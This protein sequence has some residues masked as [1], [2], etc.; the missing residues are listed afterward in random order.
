ML[1][2][3][4]ASIISRSKY[5]QTDMDNLKAEAKRHSEGKAPD[6]MCYSHV[7]DYIDA[8]GYGGIQKNGF[9]DAIPPA[10]WG[11]AHDFADYLN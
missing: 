9:N 8:T 10:Y 4:S 6:G 11:E 7:A 3:D 2:D 5:C 1:L